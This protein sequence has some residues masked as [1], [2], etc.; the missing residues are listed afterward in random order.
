M[1]QVSALQKVGVVGRVAGRMAGRHLQ[2]NRWLRAGLS[3]ARITGAHFGRILHLLGLEIAGVF[4]LFFAVA[5]SIACWRE[6]HLWSAGKIGPGRTLLALVFA[7]TF[8]WFGVTSFCRASRKAK[9][10]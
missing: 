10:G 3:A 8:A 2:Q 6:Y 5:G 7:L 9:R 1:S 4:Y